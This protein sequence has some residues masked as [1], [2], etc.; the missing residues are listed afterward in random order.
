[1][2]ELLNLE[3][4]KTLNRN[5]QKNVRG[6]DYVMDSCFDFCPGTVQGNIFTGQCTCITGS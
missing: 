3:G 4:V 5:A 2:K 1:M 6:G